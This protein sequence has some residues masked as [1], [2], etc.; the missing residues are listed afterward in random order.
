[1]FTHLK[2]PTH[3]HTHTHTNRERQRQKDGRTD[4]EQRD[5]E[6]ER[7]PALD[8]A[9][10]SFDFGAVL[11]RIGYTLGLALAASQCLI[12]PLSFFRI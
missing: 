7:E 5:R 9:G 8:V 11:S 3:P 12:E 2:S 1:M 4:G 10:A 6:R